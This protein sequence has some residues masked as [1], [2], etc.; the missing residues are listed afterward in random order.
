MKKR[1]CVY[2]MPILSLFCVASCSN[3]G[4]DKEVNHYGENM[5]ASVSGEIYG[6]G[7]VDLGLSV[8]WATCNVGASQPLEYGDLFSWG[9]TQAKG[10]YK[11][12]TYKWCKGAF[13]QLTKY[14]DS[15]QY[16]KVDNVGVLMSED[17]AATVNM[18]KSWRTPTL[19]EM[20]ELVKGCDWAWSDNFNGKGIAGQVGVSKVNGNVIF[21]PAAGYSHDTEIIDKGS[22]G[23]YWTSTVN[24]V[25]SYNAYVFIF[26]DHQISGFN[27]Y[28]SDGR[29]VRAVLN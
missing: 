29:S 16:G 26:Y 19:K 5:S 17:D 28:R 8:K 7:Y 14:C 21:L 23:G 20:T 12:S 4:D 13:D 2:I 25:N 9:E 22:Y 6:Y 15:V 27:Y 18:G 11:W 24:S 3:E 10:L 1:F